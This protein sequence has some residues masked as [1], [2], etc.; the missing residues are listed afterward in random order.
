MP[1][2]RPLPDDPRDRLRPG[3]AIELGKKAWVAPGDVGWSFSRS[4]GPGG[5]NVNKV[6]TKV[7][8]RFDLRGCTVLSAAVKARLAKKARLDA[9]G[10]VMVSSQVTR[11]RTMNLTDARQ[12]L[13]AMIRVALVPPKKR[14]ATNPSRGAQR[15]RLDAK[16]RQ[17]DKKRQRRAPDVS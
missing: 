2:E 6:S 14:K 4:G 17:S 10:R 1:D 3:D 5:Q 12:R 9:E 7:D 11:N 15:R 8:L 16:R 13:A